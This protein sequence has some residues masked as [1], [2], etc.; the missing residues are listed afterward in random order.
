MKGSIWAVSLHICVS[1]R[2][3][4]AM[5]VFGEVSERSHKSRL[6]PQMWEGVVQPNT[7]EGMA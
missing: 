7:V 5:Q 2:M 6:E 3:E 4:K 1:I